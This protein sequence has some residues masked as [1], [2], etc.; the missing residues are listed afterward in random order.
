MQQVPES[1]SMNSKTFPSK[2]SYS[3]LAHMPK[4]NLIE[5][6]RLLEKN[7]YSAEQMNEQQARNC[8]E[9]L[10]KA[11]EKIAKLKV[12]IAYLEE[13]EGRK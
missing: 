6:I 1:Q 12:Y 2:Y 9:L 5:Y 7:C 8:E 10:K 11:D 4:D 3:T 13:G